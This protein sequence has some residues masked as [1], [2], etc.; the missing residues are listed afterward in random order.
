MTECK[1]KPKYEEFVDIIKEQTKECNFLHYVIQAMESVIEP[2]IR[3]MKKSELAK[4]L[5]EA[6]YYIYCT[7]SWLKAKDVNI[8][9]FQRENLKYKYMLE[10]TPSKVRSETA[11]N[12]ALAKLEN[13]PK[14]KALKEIE[15]EFNKRKGHFKRRGYGAAFVREMSK[16][17]PIIESQKTI[18]ELVRKLKLKK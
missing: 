16:K 17:Y 7:E 1:T 3:E 15:S 11:R 8:E 12:A 6:V 9:H 5:A 10:I 4:A 18:E 2:Q 13:D 14:Q